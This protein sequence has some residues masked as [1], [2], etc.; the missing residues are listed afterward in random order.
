[1]RKLILPAIIL[2][3]SFNVKAQQQNKIPCADPVYRQFDFWAGEWNVFDTKGAKAGDSK[4]S[5]ILDSCV[6]LEEWT[7]TAV[8]NGFRYSGKSFNTYN[9]ATKQWQQTWIDNAAGT[10]EFL[11]GEG[12]DGKII[13]YADKVVGADGK[14]F[15]RRLTFTKLSEDKV[16]QFGERSDDG[17]NTWKTEYDL[18]Y[19][20]R[21]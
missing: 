19:R 8:T 5:I 17:G 11:R 3:I 7:S 9:A 20:R 13:L 1:M 14:S 6:I 2:F 15:L 18:E 10:T 16:R 21:K 4:I 12:S